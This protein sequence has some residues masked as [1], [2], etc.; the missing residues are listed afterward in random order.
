LHGRFYCYSSQLL[1]RTATAF[2]LEE[3]WVG[4]GLG[5]E[6]GWVGLGLRLERRWVDLK[7]EKRRERWPRASQTASS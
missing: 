5:L 4:L 1:S 3:E 6:R 7:K 2:G